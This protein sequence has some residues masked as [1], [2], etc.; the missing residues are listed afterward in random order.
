MS[1]FYKPNI[2]NKNKKI[3]TFGRMQALMSSDDQYVGMK[4]GAQITIETIQIVNIEIIRYLILPCLLYPGL[5]MDSLN[6]R[7]LKQRKF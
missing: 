2:F 3:Y 4:R 7:Y 1:V 5:L 6:D